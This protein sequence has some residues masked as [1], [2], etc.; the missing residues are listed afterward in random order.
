MK[1]YINKLINV[2][3]ICINVLSLSKYDLLIYINK[4]YM[5]TQHPIP[6]KHRFSLLLGI[7]ML[8]ENVL[9]C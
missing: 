9:C 1:M 7:N 3:L 8:N 5:F 6:C 2:L 4:K